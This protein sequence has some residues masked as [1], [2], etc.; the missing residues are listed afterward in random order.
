MLTPTYNRT[1]VDSSKHQYPVLIMN[2]DTVTDICL[3]AAT[4]FS[5]PALC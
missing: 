1:Y 2:N 3:Y 5:F 4:G